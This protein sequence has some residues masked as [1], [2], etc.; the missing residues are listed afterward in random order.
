MSDFNLMLLGFVVFAYLFGSI[1][2]AVLL[3]RLFHLPDPRQN[4]SKNPGATNMLRLYGFKMCLGVLIIDLLKGMIPVYLAYRLHLPFVYL[5]VITIAACLGHIFPCFF[6]FR[7]GKGVATAFGALLLISATSSC[8]IFLTWILALIAFGY[9]S[10]A[11]MMTCVL[12]PLII[13]LIRPEF[14][15]P[16]SMLAIL[17]LLRHLINLTRLMAHQEPKLNFFRK[18]KS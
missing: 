4:G 15:I 2:G 12:T 10:I 17:I 18:R 8:C 6:R 1:S 5:G 16:A 3:S 9:A 14:T 11:T 7:G 13:W